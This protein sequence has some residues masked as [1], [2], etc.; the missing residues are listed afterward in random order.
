MIDIYKFIKSIF[1]LS[2]PFD[3]IF[4]SPSRVGLIFEDKIIEDKH[5]VF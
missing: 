3:E 5:K 2:S 4:S 1:S